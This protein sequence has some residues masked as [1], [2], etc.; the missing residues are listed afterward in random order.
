[1]ALREQC[2]SFA[3]LC[4]KERRD[5]ET[6]VAKFKE[7]GSGGTKAASSGETKMHAINTAAAC[8]TRATNNVKEAEALQAAAVQRVLDMKAAGA[9]AAAVERADATAVV[10]RDATSAATFETTQAKR[11]FKTTSALGRR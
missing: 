6:Y 7:I 11:C 2:E 3:R 1:M 8:V 5:C 4:A 9:P 10:V